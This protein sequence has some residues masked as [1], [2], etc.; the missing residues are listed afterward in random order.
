MRR[1]PRLDAM[2]KP[3]SIAV[4][5]ASRDQPGASWVDMFGQLVEF[6][7]RG[8]L[9][10][11]N[12]K[13]DV[14]RGYKAYAGLPDLP[15]PVDLVII[16]LSAPI[17]PWILRDCVATG[18]RNVH[19][20][21]AGFG[22]T[23]EDQGKTLQEEITQI[24]VEGDLRVIGPNSMGVF[25]PRLRLVTWAGAP[26][27]IGS[28]GILT[29]SGGFADAILGYGSQIGLSFSTVVNY[30]TGLTVDASDLV[31][32]LSDDP[33]TDTI[34]V[35]LEGVADGRRLFDAVAR[36]TPDKPVVMVKPGASRAARRTAAS[37]TGS[38]AGDDRIWQG[39]FAQSGAIRVDSVQDMAHTIDALKRLPRPAGPN[40]AIIG[41]GGG[42][43]VVA[44]DACSRAG[45]DVPRLSAEA[46]TELRKTI[47]A[48]GNIITNPV[49]AHDV[50]TDPAQ[51]PPVLEALSSQEYLDM[52]VVYFHI[53]WMYDVAPD[54]VAAL[55]TFLA[56]SGSA[57]M[58][59]K[60]LV[61]TWRSYRSGPEYGK[62]IQEMREIL[63]D[64][65]IPLFPDIDS[66]ARTLARLADYSSFVASAKA[67]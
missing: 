61:A 48:A 40:V 28:V 47:P 32:Y 58:N 42:S 15:E 5:G 64:G 4:V 23:G 44:A 67:T 8:R 25:S 52:V 37:H 66:T 19:I 60:P 18:N 7:Y 63:V 46:R 24:A 36:T 27:A 16:G 13:A 49:D 6:G 53:D 45:L 1:S 20:F 51:M 12:P 17:V 2:L 22:E 31:E 35:Y 34:G 30:G 65:G 54:R 56:E 11:I 3:E 62:V 29:Q 50:M 21:S 55:A 43:S 26:E 41:T 14:I 59:G 38:L 10:P 57:Y 9:Y 39:F 33:E